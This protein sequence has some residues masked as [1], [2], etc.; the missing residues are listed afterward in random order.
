[1]YPYQ[2]SVTAFHY[3]YLLICP[4]SLLDS[5]L[6][7]H[8]AVYFSSWP[9][10]L[11]QSLAYTLVLNI[12]WINEWMTNKDMWLNVFPLFV[13]CLYRPLSVVIICRYLYSARHNNFWLVISKELF[14]AQDRF[15][16][17][18]RCLTCKQ[19]PQAICFFPLPFFSNLRRMM[20]SQAFTCWRV[21]HGM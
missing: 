12:C 20:T 1:M 9:F 11:A 16:S 2:L 18:I 5:E 21:G 17:S 6:R 10:C 8:R 15:C 13:I 7:E 4:S 14:K 3:K 19:Q